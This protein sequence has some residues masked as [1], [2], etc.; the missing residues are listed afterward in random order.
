[1]RPSENIENT[2]KKMNFT[3]GAELREQILADALK[4]HEQ[5]ET[6]PAIEKPN[7]WRTIMKN[8]TTK[9]AAAAVIVIAVIA[10]VSQFF[11]GTVTFAD[12]IKPILN[13]RTVVFDFVMGKEETGIVVHD[14][15]VGNRIRRTLS[16]IDTIMVMDLDNAKM[17][18][19]DPKH[20]GAMYMDIG[21]MIQEG[22][23]NIIGL[24]RNIVND[25]EKHP[26]WPIE[27]LGQREI[28]GQK[29]IGFMVRSKNEELTIWADPVTA[30][31]VRIEVLFGQ[32]SAIIKNIEFDVP[33]DE[34]LVS[35]EP[36]AGY[37]LGNMEY[38]MNQ[39]TEEDFV[40]SLR[41][42]AEILRDG[43]FPETLTAEGYLKVTSLFTEKL[44][45]LNLSPEEGTH[46]G[47]TFGRGLMFFQVIAGSNCDLHY[48][49]GGVKLG[50]A[51]KA[52]FW[53]QPKG[54]ETYR[55]IYGDLHVEDVKADQLPK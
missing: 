9:L 50:D 44:D 23:K 29:A 21:G 8:R 43:S 28:D 39:F 17:L 34:S 45:Q 35:M 27:E 18:T 51:E 22:T 54:A 32:L 10:G 30:K 14:I 2:I 6:Q 42:W 13:A 53:Y 19:L 16:N 55:V 24:V 46:I 33:V 48:A 3:A 7:I 36:P 40:E 11:G 20:K 4:A 52:I 15:V 37:T 41:T 47:M 25:I 1:M 38:K 31:P 26:D 12:V 49:G 5:T